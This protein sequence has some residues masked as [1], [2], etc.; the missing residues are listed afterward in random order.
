VLAWGRHCE[1]DADVAESGDEGEEDRFAVGVDMTD[2]VTMGSKLRRN[3]G[4]DRSE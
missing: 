4:H 2:F 3:E 1:L